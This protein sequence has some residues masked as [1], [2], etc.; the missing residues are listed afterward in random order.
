M[1]L[2]VSH[3]VRQRPGQPRF[4]DQRTQH[5]FFMGID[6]ALQL[7][8]LH[9]AHSFQVFCPCLQL[10]GLLAQGGLAHAQPSQCWRLRFSFCRSVRGVR[11]HFLSPCLSNTPLLIARVLL[12]WHLGLETVKQYQGGKPPK[13][14]YTTGTGCVRLAGPA[15][16]GHTPW[17]SAIAITSPSLPDVGKRGK[18]WRFF[19]FQHR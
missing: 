9:V 18:A 13:R 1:P 15:I 5:D 10:R 2:V 3:G 6:P 14:T 11:G 8:G 4:F 17:G 19:I 12:I 16:A 7:L